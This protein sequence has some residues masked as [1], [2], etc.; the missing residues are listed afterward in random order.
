V[1]VYFPLLIVVALILLVFFVFA[2]G[3]SFERRIRGSHALQDERTQQ[4]LNTGSPVRARILS[5]SDTG[6]RMRPHYIYAEVH[7]RIYPENGAEYEMKTFISV[8]AL[9]IP[10]FVPG[11]EISARID[12]QTKEVAIDYTKQ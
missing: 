11:R 7:F 5:I 6:V 10:T 9:K 3:R 1:S 12:A 2:G 8:P 4:I